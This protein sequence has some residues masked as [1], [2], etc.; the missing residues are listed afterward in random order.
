M[1]CDV[2]KRSRK[3][4]NTL[5]IIIFFTIFILLFV[6]QTYIIKKWFIEKLYFSNTTKQYLTYLLYLLF[7]ILLFYPLARYF[8]I[9]PNWL[10]GILSIPIGIIFITFCITILYKLSHLAFY[11]SNFNSDRRIFFKKSADISAISLAIATNSNAMLNAKNIEIETINIKIR[12]LKKSYKIVQISDAHIGGLIDK[13]FI[14]SLVTKVN[15][16]KPDIVVI[17]GDLVDTKLEFAK[18]ALDELKNLNSKFGNY[19]I[20]GNHEYFHGVK[21]IID[22]VNSLNIKTLE[23]ENVYIG[24]FNDGFYLCGVYDMFGLRYGSFL[25]DLEKSLK[26]TEDQPTILLAHQ[27]KYINEIKDTKGID[28]ILCGHTHG[29]QIIPFN[30]LVHLQQPYIKGLHQHNKH[31]KIYVNKGT[32][33]WGPPMRLGTTSEITL[34]NIS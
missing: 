2:Y 18:P 13:T 17:T 22:Y 15:L 1:A 20:I 21:P 6:L 33:F 29:G 5:N 30:L 28:L 26:N 4:D 23:N 8:P 14:E 3:E 32:G 16:L 27:P 31:T 11:K 34:I 25:P 19:F 24:E 12:N 7:V 9:I 10:Y